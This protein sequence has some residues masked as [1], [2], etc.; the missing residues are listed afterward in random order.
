MKEQDSSTGWFLRKFFLKLIVF[1]LTKISFSEQATVQCVC[2][3]TVKNSKLATE[4][5]FDNISQRIKA[6]NVVAKGKYVSAKTR[7]QGSIFFL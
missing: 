2:A 4:D 1:N 5:N 6:C 7:N 3:I